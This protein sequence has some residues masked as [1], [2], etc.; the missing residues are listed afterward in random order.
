MRARIK[1]LLRRAGL[2]LHRYTPTASPDAQLERVLDRF[3]IDLILDIGACEGQYG[4]LVR[5]LGYRGRIVSFEPLPAVYPI[6]QA[7]AARDPHWTVAARG[8]IG[9]EDGEITINV[10]GNAAS[11]SVLPMLAAHTDAAPVSAYVGQELVAV[12]RLDTAALP[13]LKGSAATFLKIDTQGYEAAVLAGGRETLARAAA[14]QV[15]MSLTP[16]YAGGTLYDEMLELMR[17][18]G[19][20]LWALWPG[21]GREHDGRLLQMDAIFARPERARP[22]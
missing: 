8:A 6:L 18:H 19:F 15:E 9:A 3:G 4:K 1:R 10:A 7:Q 14:V 22:A 13:L 17:G 5:E 20:E 11:S 16:L 21:F 12:S 2:D